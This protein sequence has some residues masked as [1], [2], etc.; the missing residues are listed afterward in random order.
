M[1]PD[2]NIERLIRRDLVNFMAYSGATSPETLEGKTEVAVKDIIKLD[3]NENPYGCS[4]RVKKALRKYADFHVYTD[5]KQTKLR[6]LLAGYLNIDGRH[7]VA[8]S[9][10]NQLIDLVIR[11]L[12]NPGDEVVSCTPTFGIYNFS[13]KL[14]GGSLV[15]VPRDE[16]YTVNIRTLKAAVSNKT[17]LVCLA[18]P[19]N[20]TGTLMPRDDILDLLDTGVPVLL[21]EAYYEFCG[22]TLA[23]AIGHYENLMILRTFS[24]WAGL[25]GLRI[26]YGLFPEN[27]ADY[28]MRIKMPYN[29]NVAAMIAVKESLADL[30]YLMENV[31]AIVL[32]RER[33]FRELQ[34][35]GW[36]Q[37]FPSQANFIL[38]KVMRGGARIF[39]QSLQQKGILVRYF[40]NALLRNC[41]R[42]SVGK[43]EQTD[44]LLVAL[45]EIAADEEKA[46]TEHSL[47]AMLEEEEHNHEH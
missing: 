43:P 1:E 7:I 15:E 27:I 40:D 28:I 41:I 10:S 12:V 19:N 25:A 8:G 30:D 3:A 44:A 6:E 34:Q 45:R 29:V 46:A 22:E 31:K 35:F 24:K 26:G 16:N 4:P 9:G 20:P 18:N 38:C 33:L 2:F 21:D 37:V 13:T 23:A 14:C 5:D 42:I 47:E 39:K 11:L 17:K 36:L 32:E